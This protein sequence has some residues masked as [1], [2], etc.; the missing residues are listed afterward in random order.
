MAV[1]RERSISV[2]PAVMSFE[3]EALTF[4]L[5]DTYPPTRTSAHWDFSEGTYRF[6]LSADQ[7][8]DCHNRMVFLLA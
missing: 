1:E 6:R 4:D 2:S 3:R 7:P 8:F 5:L